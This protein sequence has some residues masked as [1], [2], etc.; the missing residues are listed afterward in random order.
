MR[1]LLF[2]LGFISMFRPVDATEKSA[3][4]SINCLSV[5]LLPSTV[6]QFDLTY[7]LDFTTDPNEPVPNNEAT[8]PPRIG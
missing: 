4:V 8:S 5:R 2:L 3:S 6:K 1:H 7:R